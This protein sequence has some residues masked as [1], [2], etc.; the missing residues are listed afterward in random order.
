[1]G[2]VTTLRTVK[3]MGTAIGEEFCY[4]P[5]VFPFLL[6]DDEVWS[7]RTLKIT[8]RIFFSFYILFRFE[9]KIFTL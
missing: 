7:F 3:A 6:S 2:T 9:I 8:Q 4:L 1:M 5:K